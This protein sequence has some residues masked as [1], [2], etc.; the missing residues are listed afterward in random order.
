MVNDPNL[1]KKI[2]SQINNI[3]FEDVDNAIKEVDKE[4]KLEFKELTDEQ[5]IGYQEFQL[6]NNELNKKLVQSIKING[7]IQPLIARPLPNGKYQILSG[8]NR[9]LCGRKAGIKKF[10]C[11]IIYGL[12]DDNARDLVI[13]SN[14]KAM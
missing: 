11:I 13:N 5:L 8:R 2:I 10:P 9:R 4:W 1:I 3:T 6:Y 12:T 7:I 14:I